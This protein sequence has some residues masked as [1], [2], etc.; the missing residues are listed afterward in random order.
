MQLSLGLDRGG[1]RVTGPGI[2]WGEQAMNWE[3]NDL[4]FWFPKIR[5]AGVLVPRTE[6]VQ[7][8]VCLTDI[9]DGKT[10]I[11][12]NQ[13]VADL[14]AAGHRIG[15]PPWFLRTG[16]TSGKHDWWRTCYVDDPEILGEH[17]GELVTFSAMADFIGL[18]TN[19]WAVREFLPLQVGFHAFRGRMPIAREY[20]AFLI[21]RKLACIHPYFPEA[22]LGDENPDRSDWRPILAQMHK[23]NIWVVGEIAEIVEKVSAVLDGNWSIDVCPTVD[24]RWYLTDC[25]VAEDSF[26]WPECPYA[27]KQQQPRPLSAA[28]LEEQVEVATRPVLWEGDR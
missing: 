20:R 6:I 24:G 25:A 14:T 19:T 23:I 22:S 13:F 8:N 17:V 18:P 2:D 12:F 21:D 3:R 26:H 15:P 9:L 10:P 27:L 11:G 16:Q 5:D 4:A 28:E 1:V 7:A